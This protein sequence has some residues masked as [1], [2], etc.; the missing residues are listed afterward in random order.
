[1]K[2]NLI[3]IGIAPIAWLNDDMPNLTS[4]ISVNQCLEEI[5][6][7]GYKGVE[8]CDSFPKKTF[9]IKKLLKKFN[10]K[11]SGG[12]YSG[13]LL[14]I[15]VNDEFK[16][17][18]N[19]LKVFRDMNTKNIAFCECTR[20]IQSKN[21]SLYKKP[22]LKMNERVLF[23]KKLNELSQKVYEKFG[24]NISYHHHMGTIIQ[25]KNEIDMLLSSTSD[26]VKLLLDT[27]HLL[28][29]N[30]NP[31][32][33]YKLYKDRI[34][35]YHFKDVRKKIIKNCI[36]KKYSFRESFLNGAFTV[37]GD[38]DYDFSILLNNLKK[39][40][41]KG[42]IIVEAEQDPKKYSP[43]KLSLKGY[44]YLKKLLKKNK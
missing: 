21:I 1:M 24:V 44:L 19:T 32:E 31:L 35:H 13:S 36:K 38:G 34:T 6:K 41:Y 12:W 10:L 22:L 14:S 42:W 18:S 7:C 26:H 37:P 16:K 33:I 40:K 28:F 39:D 15:S 17:M 43:Y 5:N 3:K 27:G 11:F 2:T 8:N 4:H 20:S 23:F 25:N 29:A 30:E 9:E